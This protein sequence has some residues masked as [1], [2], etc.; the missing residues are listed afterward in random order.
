M[1]WKSLTTSEQIE[2]IKQDSQQ[3]PVVIYKHS[4]RCGISS[5]V[6]SR[7]ERA[8]NSHE[9]PLV[10][11]YFLDLIRYRDI[12]QLVATTFNVQHESPQVLVI[13][14]GTSVYDASH[15]MVSYPKIKEQVVDLANS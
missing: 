10:D 8:W 13:N 2:Q 5:M 7:L 14:Q 15:T 12:S 1:E 3:H 6:L 4:T 9:I 11:A